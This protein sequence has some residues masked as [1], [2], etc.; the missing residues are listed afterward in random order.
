VTIDELRIP[1]GLSRHTIH[2]YVRREIIPPPEGRGR[3]ARYT[4]RHVAAIRAWLK[5]RHFHVT[6][7]EVVRYCQAEGISLDE[8]VD[9]RERA[10]QSFGLGAG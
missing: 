5:L 2:D 3:R 9:R 8:Y 10:I 6:G 7:A 1:F 4:R